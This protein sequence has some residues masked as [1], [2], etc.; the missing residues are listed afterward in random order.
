MKPDFQV[1][2]SRFI[3][4]ALFMAVMAGS[5]D[6][7]WHIAVGRESFWVPPHLLLYSSV[8]GAIGGGIYGWYRTGGK[9]W[10]RLG[11]VL[12]LVPLSAPFDELWHRLFGAEN[13]SSPLIIW[14][15][16][17]V[18]L[19][20][21]LMGSFVLLLPLLR[22]DRDIDAQRLFGS[23]AFAGIL[24]LLFFL[25]DPFQPTGPWRLIGFWGAGMVAAVFSGVIVAAQRWMPGLAPATI[26][27]G[28]FMIL[29]AIEFGEKVASEVIIPPH[30]HPPL[31]LIAFS[32]LV[33]ALTVDLV[34]RSPLWLRGGLAGILRAAIFYGFASSF[35]EPQFRY[36]TENALIAVLSSLIGGLMA[37]TFVALVYQKIGVLAAKNRLDRDKLGARRS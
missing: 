4:V 30:A 33:P 7:W 15:P 29:I 26:V 11:L 9:T 13:L 23:L 1:L 22:E 21:S 2:L 18:V 35:Y 12:L 17:H 8:I 31:W 24:W 36:T 20:A 3:T 5:W 28:A 27:T 16:P 19:V 14:S 25:A 6:A 34:R 32:H 10:Q 37:G